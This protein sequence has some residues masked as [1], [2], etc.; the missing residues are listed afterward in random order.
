MHA[1]GAAPLSVVLLAQACLSR[2]VV[3][4]RRRLQEELLLFRVEQGAA[5]ALFCVV[6]AA[7]LPAG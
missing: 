5:A 1:A 2:C 4:H 7:A 3:Q 6:H